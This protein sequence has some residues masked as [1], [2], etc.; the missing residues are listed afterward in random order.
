MTVD[1]PRPGAASRIPRH[2]VQR[3]VMLAAVL[4]LAVAAGAL[5]PLSPAY[6][7]DQIVSQT[8]ATGERLNATPDEITLTFSS[9]PLDVG[10]TILVVDHHLTEWSEGSPRLDGTSI[11]QDLSADMPEGVYEVRW[12]MVSADGHP[13][14]ESFRFIV[15]ASTPDD[16]LTE[17]FPDR[18]DP[19][20]VDSSVAA[21]DSAQEP[22][23]LRVVLFA[24]GGA[25]LAGAAL[26]LLWWRRRIDLRGHAS[27]LSN[28]NGDER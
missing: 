13:L 25:V 14:S 2:G 9:E 19:T 22:P 3:R 1:M 28:V 27:G 18:A 4:M 7:H 5:V 17:P 16:L 20:P 12:R 8:P 21:S 6:G 11:V 10:A 23:V 15:G 24:V 26:V